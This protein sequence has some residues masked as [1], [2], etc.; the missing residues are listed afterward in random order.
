MF[1]RRT[2]QENMQQFRNEEN[3]HH[4]RS[5]P[6]KVVSSEYHDPNQNKYHK[7]DTN[8]LTTSQL[9]SSPTINV[10][11]RFLNNS[12]PSKL[13][14]YNNHQIQQSNENANANGR[15]NDINLR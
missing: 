10:N 5:S 1:C 15:N 13:N 3:S 9:N 2:V 4:H 12:T 14:L 7:T 11:N 8:I 6:N